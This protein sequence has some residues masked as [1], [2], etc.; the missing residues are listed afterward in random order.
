MEPAPA[1]AH[2]DFPPVGRDFDTHRSSTL[3]Q[4]D[5]LQD[6]MGGQVNHIQLADRLGRNEGTRAVR[7]KINC[8]RARMNIEVGD[9]P[10]RPGVNRVNEAGGLARDIEPIPIRRDGDP[11][12]LAP[13]PGPNVQSS[14][15]QCA[16]HWPR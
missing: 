5:D 13:R 12:R 2:I 8:A 6:L 11:F 16:G 1:R 7:Q 3:W 10:A 15:P 4:R 14:R 9:F